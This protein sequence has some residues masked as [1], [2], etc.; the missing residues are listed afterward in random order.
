MA[1]YIPSG[2]DAFARWRDQLKT[3]AT[4]MGASVGVAPADLTQL[5]TDNTAVHTGITDATT[6]AAAARQAT[7]NKDNAIA[8]AERNARTLARRIK[9]HPACT[10]AIGEALGI[11]SPGAGGGCWL[12]FGSGWCHLHNDDPAQM[13][14]GAALR[15]YYDAAQVDGLRTRSADEE[16]EARPE[17]V[18]PWAAVYG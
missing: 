7:R 1:D 12:N 5:G 8:L 13:L 18:P 11:E 2:D 9:A 10:P 3:A 14:S 4:D 15:L 6:T 16:A 17:V